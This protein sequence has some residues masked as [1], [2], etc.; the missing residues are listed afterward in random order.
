MATLR[1]AAMLLENENL[2]L[3]AKVQEL[4]K[5]LIKAEGGGAQQLQLELDRLERQLVSC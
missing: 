4:T 1:E 2:R 3:V 5:R